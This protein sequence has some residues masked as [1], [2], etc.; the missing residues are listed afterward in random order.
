MSVTGQPSRQG[1]FIWAHG[2]NTYDQET[3]VASVFVRGV[4]RASATNSG[5]EWVQQLELPP[6]LR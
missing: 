5:A 1:L 3:S 6:I 4:Q 2:I